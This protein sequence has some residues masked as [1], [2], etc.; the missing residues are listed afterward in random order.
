VHRTY[1]NRHER[2]EHQAIVE[3]ALAGNADEAVR[4]LSAHYRETADIILADA[5][6]FAKPAA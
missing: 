3:A 4:L 1:P 5:R 2:V 6:L